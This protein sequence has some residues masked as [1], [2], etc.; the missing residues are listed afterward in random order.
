MPNYTIDPEDLIKQRIADRLAIEQGL[1]Q[2]GADLESRMPVTTAMPNATAEAQGI[3]TPEQVNYTMNQLQQRF[4][5]PGATPPVDVGATI[6]SNPEQAFLQ[7]GMSPVMAKELAK[8][9]T[10]A[11]PP[12]LIGS[13][14]FESG[15]G[16][17]LG[18]GVEP[19]DVIASL[20]GMAITRNLP[21]DQAIAATFKIGGL[22]RAIKEAQQKAG[23]ETINQLLTGGNLAVSQGNLQVKQTEEATKAAKVKALNDWT[24]LVLQRNARLPGVPYSIG[25]RQQMIALGISAGIPAEQMKMLMEK[26]ITEVVSEAKI[27]QDTLQASG[28]GGEGLKME[29]SPTGA[30]ATVGASRAEK[31]I[32]PTELMLLAQSGKRGPS[33]PAD[34]TQDDAKNW[35]QGEVAK[36]GTI[37][38]TKLRSADQIKAETE[39]GNI[40]RTDAQI[41]GI[42]RL[43]DKI[44]TAES[45]LAATR[46]A[47]I[48]WAQSKISAT[49]AGRYN[50]A[51]NAFIENLRQI[52]AAKG[53]LTDRDVDRISG[54]L[55][56]FSD[57]V[58]SKNYKKV[59]LMQINKY[60]MEAQQARIEG[61][62]IDEKAFRARLEKD[63]DELDQYTRGGSKASTP[64]GIPST[65]EKV[66]D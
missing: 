12:K 14:I 32:S 16:G 35:L 47:G 63:L 40:L 61:R 42:F 9:I 64:K 20:A 28:M 59:K 26:P 36:A 10:N 65:A 41:Q 39:I 11:A 18:S 24:N 37:N 57:S 46:N 43:A 23:A 22:P 30:K 60:S 38:M 55:P 8:H 54:F 58:S 49:D 27:L 52:A 56:T 66:E 53:V 34:I 1:P 5:P 4:P 6:M 31:T 62:A 7:M 21:Q 45:P 48:L 3:A 13:D 50:D 51:K 19:W 29:I 33:I 44:I 2:Q 15:R 17:I 25:E